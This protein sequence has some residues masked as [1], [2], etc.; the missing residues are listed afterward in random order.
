VKESRSDFS[1]W[2]LFPATF[3]F[4]NAESFS[5]ELIRLLTAHFCRLLPTEVGRK[6]IL[7]CSYRFRFVT[8]EIPFASCTSGTIFYSCDVSVT[9]VFE[10]MLLGNSNNNKYVTSALPE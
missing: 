2:W 5:G 1:H 10:I 4:T 3:A 9:D 8:K 7:H 6:F